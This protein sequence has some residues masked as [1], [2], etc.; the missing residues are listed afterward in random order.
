MYLYFISCII[1]L[2]L[3]GCGTVRAFEI[4]QSLRYNQNA[5]YFHYGTAR[6]NSF[7]ELICF[8]I[9]AEAY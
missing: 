7:V 9:I 2:F 8:K 3:V 1:Y 6:P 5:L 4:N